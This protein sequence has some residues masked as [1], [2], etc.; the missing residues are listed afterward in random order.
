MAL[1]MYLAMKHTAMYMEIF[2]YFKATVTK[3]TWKF[4]CS[5]QISK[6]FLI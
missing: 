5:L 3:L 2:M 1:F 6:H 4:P